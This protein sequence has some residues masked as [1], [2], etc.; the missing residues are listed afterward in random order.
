MKTDK[1]IAAAA[2][3]FA[4]RWQGKGYERGES[5]PFWIDLLTNVFGVENLMDFI[6]YEERVS[7]MV[8]STNFIDGHIPS[9]KVL[10]EQ[11]SIDKDLRAPIPQSEGGKLTPF[12]QAK[13]YIA[14]MPLSQQPKLSSTPEPLILIVHWPTCMMKRSCLS[15]FA[16]PTRRTTAL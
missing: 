12:Q 2:A 13:K 1:Q 7:S 10:I 16:K 9:T 11:K 6:H 5:Q 14:N 15:N 8:D 3:A 4:E